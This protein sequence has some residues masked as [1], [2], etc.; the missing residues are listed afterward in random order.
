MT[1]DKGGGDI[2]DG[3]LAVFKGDLHF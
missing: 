3:Y 2:L 1:G